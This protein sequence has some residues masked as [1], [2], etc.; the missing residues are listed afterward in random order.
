MTIIG[1]IHKQG[2]YEGTA[3]DNHVLHCT[4]ADP[5]AFGLI[6]ETVKIKTENLNQCFG[7]E[8]NADYLAMLVGEEITP[9]YDKYGKV[10]SIRFET[11][12]TNVDVEEKED[13]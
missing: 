4:V 3:Y 10:I 11:K 8:V 13:E 2:I 5:N 12:N 6:T 1:I 7:C 9:Y